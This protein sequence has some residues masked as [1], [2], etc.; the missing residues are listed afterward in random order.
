M[1][2]S[3]GDG[4]GLK[5]TRDSCEACLMGSADRGESMGTFETGSESGR[6]PRGGGFGEE[7]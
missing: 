2:F 4:D 6:V 3:S 1:A 7:G 5:S